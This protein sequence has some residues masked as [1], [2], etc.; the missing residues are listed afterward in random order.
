MFFWSC[1][2]GSIFL[3]LLSYSV[4]QGETIRYGSLLLEGCMPEKQILHYI[5]N[6]AN[7]ELLYLVAVACLE[8]LAELKKA[9]GVKAIIDAGTATLLKMIK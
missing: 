3:I 1:F 7:G 8:R 5:K 6:E 2:Y 4:Q 9:G